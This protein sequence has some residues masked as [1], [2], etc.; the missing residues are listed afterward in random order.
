MADAFYVHPSA[1]VDP[2]ARIGLGSKIW[3]FCHVMSGAEIGADV[4]LGQNGYVASTAKIGDGC[5]IQ[6]NVSLYDGVELA[7]G[8]FVGPSAVFTNVLRPRAR[9][10]RRDKFA[11]TLVGE[12]ASLGANCTIVC[13]VT[14]GRGAM[15]GAGCT[16]VRDVPAFAI[17]VGNPARRV[18]WACLCG[19]RLPAGAD[20]WCDACGRRYRVSASGPIEE[21]SRS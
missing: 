1:I 12:D 8:V 14:I 15:I 6:N 18:G 7:K 16:V 17:L 5:R 19:E 4:V 2:G 11:K 13:G 21:T 3:H 9:F 20:A 10:P